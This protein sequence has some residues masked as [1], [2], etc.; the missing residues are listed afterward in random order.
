M[1]RKREKKR[2]RNIRNK[3]KQNYFVNAK[4]IL[5]YENNNIILKTEWLSTEKIL[6]VLT[7]N[8]LYFYYINNINNFDIIEKKEFNHK[9][10]LNINFHGLDI[11]DFNSLNMVYNSNNS[12]LIISYLEYKEDTNITIFHLYIFDIKFL[13]IIKQFDIKSKYYEKYYINILNEYTLIILFISGIIY[14]ISLKNFQIVTIIE[15]F[16]KNDIIDYYSELNIN[17]NI[18]NF[19]N[20]KKF[21]IFNHFKIKLFGFY[22]PYEIIEENIKDD[23]YKYLELDV[24]NKKNYCFNYIESLNDSNKYIIGYSQ[25][26]QF[27]YYLWAQSPL[28]LNKYI[29]ILIYK[30]K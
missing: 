14:N 7:E 26:Y 19:K 25:F 27:L 23:K 2:E 28:F 6:V 12:T 9:N 11:I 13:S 1:E 4:D 5:S 24:F 16:D 3:S 17:I 15:A 18:F 8:Y 20:D 10:D 29:I 22:P 21:V 30:K